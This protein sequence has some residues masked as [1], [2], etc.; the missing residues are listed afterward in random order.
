[1]SSNKTKKNKKVLSGPSATLNALNNPSYTKV[2]YKYPSPEYFRMLTIKKN[3]EKKE[4]EEMDELAQLMQDANDAKKINPSLQV[5]KPTA[6]R[7]SPLIFSSPF[8]FDK[9]E[10]GGKKKTIKKRKRKTMKK[11]KYKKNKK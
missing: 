2:V 8:P 4:K 1:M 10:K 9:K 3:K 5:I 6:R 7:N 11:L